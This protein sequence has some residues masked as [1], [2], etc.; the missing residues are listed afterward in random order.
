MA[1][2]TQ[3]V[4]T[5]FEAMT[6]KEHE[7]MKAKLVKLCQSGGKKPKASTLEGY[8][9]RKYTTPEHRQLSDA[10]LKITAVV[11]MLLMSAQAG[12][13]SDERAEAI[14]NEIIAAWSNMREG[15]ADVLLDELE[16]A[17]K[18]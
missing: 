17:I 9:L 13:M 8:A 2:K 1:N 4:K 7:E 18:W 10:D 6:E 3:T 14:Y 16:K 12:G 11:T 15:F 5:Q